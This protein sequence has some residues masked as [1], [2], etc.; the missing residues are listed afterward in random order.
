VEAIVAGEPL[1]RYLRAAEALYVS[2]HKSG[3]WPVPEADHEHTDQLFNA[4][5][6][7]LIGHTSAMAGLLSLHRS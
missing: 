5:T 6:G 3:T 1:D 2:D 4:N 7:C